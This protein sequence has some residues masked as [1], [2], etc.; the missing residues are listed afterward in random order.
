MLLMM[1]WTSL[2]LLVLM[3]NL[4]L[5]NGSLNS[6]RLLLLQDLTLIKYLILPRKEC[7]AGL[8][9]TAVSFPKKKEVQFKNTSNTMTFHLMSFMFIKSG[10]RDS[11]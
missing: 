5:G 7:Y 1:P 4:I 10:N 9:V 3:G 2:D 8:K 6:L 11:I